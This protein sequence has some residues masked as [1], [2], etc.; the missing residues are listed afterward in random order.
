MVGMLAEHVDELAPFVGDT[1]ALLRSHLSAGKRVVI[2]GTQGFGLSLLHG[3][4]W[5]KATARDTTAGGF[6]SESG[7]SPLD[8]DDITMV[9]RC[10]PI[11][12][13]G[14]SGA[15]FD[16]TTWSAI[17]TESGSPLA[18][19]E[20]TTVTKKIRRVGRFDAGLVK[21]AIA[22]NRPTRIVLNHVDYID[23]RV[24]DGIIS[25][26]AYGFIARVEESIGQAVAWI[27]VGPDKLLT[28]QP[29]NSDT[30]H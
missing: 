25:A 4:Y 21:R 23:W 27:G 14:D 16:E 24:R 20:Y 11:R 10:H 28:V 22:V 8:V 2:E 9:I 6:I 26:L 15:L 30:D 19:E 3:G 17:S 5:P 1:T 29:A 13:A 7:I 12:V 18:L